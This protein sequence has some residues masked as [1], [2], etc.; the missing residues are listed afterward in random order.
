MPNK[1][2]TPH[3]VDEIYGIKVE[4]F[5]IPRPGN[6]PIRLIPQSTGRLVTHSTE[7]MPKWTPAS[8]KAFRAKNP[9]LQGEALNKAVQRAAGRA[10]VYRF[11]DWTA[12]EERAAFE[13]AIRTQSAT[14]ACAT[15]TTGNFRIAQHRMIGQQASALR[16]VHN[17]LA[18]VQIECSANTEGRTGLWQLPDGTLYPSVAVIAHAHVQY[19]IPLRVPRGFPDD[20]SDCPLPWAVMTNSRRKS[21]AWETEEGIFMHNDVDN[22]THFDLAY[23]E[24]SRI[25][26]MARRVVKGMSLD[27]AIKSVKRDAALPV[28]PVRKYLVRAGDSL[29]KIA[30][31]HKITLEELL[32][33]NRLTEKSPIHP[34]DELIVP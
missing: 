4:R 19:G 23:V 8:W 26:E 21:D 22:N 33:V 9:N 24:R 32:G 6:A 28:L 34:G 1:K 7:G 15:Y 2:I 29:Y 31:Q 17:A 27:E 25:V 20:M 11:D 3:W 16:G 14:H 5:P 10:L 13:G 18:L 12:A 30:R